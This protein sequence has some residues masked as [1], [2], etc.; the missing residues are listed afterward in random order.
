MSRGNG[1]IALG[2]VAA[3]ALVAAA[4]VL[5]AQFVGGDAVAV[6]VAASFVAGGI[7][8]SRKPI[9]RPYRSALERLRSRGEI[10]VEVGV[11]EAHI[12]RM[13]RVT[14]WTATASGA[15]T[16]AFALAAL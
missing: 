12:L 9:S 7:L 14:G 1:S 5:L 6:V 13:R 8:W 2:M 16:L 11:L 10:D 4:P 3:L 15:V